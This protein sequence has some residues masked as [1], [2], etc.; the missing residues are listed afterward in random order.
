MANSGETQRSCGYGACLKDPGRALASCAGQ[1][2]AFVPSQ[3]SVRREGHGAR[4]VY[5]NSIDT[6]VRT[7]GRAKPSKQ[8][9]GTFD[10]DADG[11]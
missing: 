2:F 3:E 8:G 7:L 9:L 5:T 11:L 1:T 6:G 10:H 4:T